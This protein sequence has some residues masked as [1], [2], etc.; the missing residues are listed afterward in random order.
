MCTDIRVD[1][2]FANACVRVFGEVNGD[3]CGHVYRQVC[4]DAHAHVYLAGVHMYACMVHTCP[5][6]HV[7]THVS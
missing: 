4:R 6:T 3:V 7:P 5:D 2:S 1:I